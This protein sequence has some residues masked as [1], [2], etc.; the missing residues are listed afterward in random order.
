[1]GKANSQNA[2]YPRLERS[3]Q[4]L[5]YST[6]YDQYQGLHQN[7]KKVASEKKNNASIVLLVP[8]KF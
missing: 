8:I 4:L 6:L 7:D 3:H 5:F 2:P 1:M